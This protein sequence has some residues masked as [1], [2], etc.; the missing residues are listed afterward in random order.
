MEEEPDELL[1]Y[2]QACDSNGDG[3]IQYDEFV[4]LLRN[5][6]ADMSDEECRIG[7]SDVDGDG[8]GSIDFEEFS[9]WWGEF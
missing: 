9:R 4:T 1:T 5:L 6:G 7:F 8:D 2:F 3:A